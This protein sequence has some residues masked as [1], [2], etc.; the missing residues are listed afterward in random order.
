MKH[1]HDTFP[2]LTLKSTEIVTT[3]GIEQ[4]QLCLEA[5]VDIKQIVSESEGET[6]T[7]LIRSI[8]D[9]LESKERDFKRFMEG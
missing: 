3:D 2:L 4:M 6:Y 5:W 1:T 9:V 7:S 8:V